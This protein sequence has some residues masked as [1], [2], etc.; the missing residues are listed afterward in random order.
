MRTNIFI[1]LLVILLTTSSG[2]AASQ[3]AAADLADT[4]TLSAEDVERLSA[5]RKA[6]LQAPELNERL[7]RLLE[8]EQQALQLAIDEPLKLGSIGSAILDIYP[9]SQ[10]GHFAMGHFYSHVESLD[11]QASHDQELARLQTHMLQ[12]GDGSRT[13]PMQVLTIYDAHAYA[14]SRGSSPVGSIYQSN[15]FVDFGFMLVARPDNGPLEQTYFDISHVLKDFAHHA[16]RAADNQAQ[17]KE[18]VDANPWTFMR[19]LAARKDTAAQAAIGRYLASIQKYDDAI[20][21][22][23]ISA[24]SGNVLANGILARIYWSQSEAAENKTDRD[25][26]RERSLENHMHAIA[27]GSTDSMYTLAIST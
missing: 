23:T 15:E 26:L 3:S 2:C 11:A 12:S 4:P 7:R 13:S 25:E 21:W 27:L 16:A 9:G 18:S 24:R 22:L 19:L 17:T 8:L 10:T 6:F 1:Y 14:E 20:N 5:Q